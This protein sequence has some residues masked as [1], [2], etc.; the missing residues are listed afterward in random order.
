MPHQRED[1][2]I[3]HAHR[4]C[5]LGY[6]YTVLA[7]S[8]NPARICPF[9]ERKKKKQ[10]FTSRYLHETGTGGG[11]AGDPIPAVLPRATTQ[12]PCLRFANGPSPT[13]SLYFLAYPKKPILNG[14]FLRKLHQNRAMP[15]DIIHYYRVNWSK[16][17]RTSNGHKRRHIDLT[18]V[19]GQMGTSGGNCRLDRVLTT[20]G[21]PGMNKT[22]FRK[23]EQLLGKAM[24]EQLVHGNS[25]AR[26]VRHC[27]CRQ[28]LPS[29][30]S[31]HQC[32]SRWRL[33]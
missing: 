30:C 2:C 21:V 13:P 16:Y 7:C 6:K 28:P 26:R 12:P 19:L 24:N 11:G 20:M 15:K 31:I 25:W 33:V 32:S 3:N 22:M 4:P 8:P 5:Q 18:A 23:T 29:G 10:R 9:C 14:N 17:T 27:Q 1:K